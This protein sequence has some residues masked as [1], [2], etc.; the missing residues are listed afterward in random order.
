M[1]S[2][3]AVPAS[4]DHLIVGASDLDGGIDFVEERTGVRAAIGGV[5]PGRGTRNAVLSLGARCYLEILAP[6]PEQPRITWFHILPQ[7]SQP[8]LVG[9]MAHVDDLSSA[10]NRLRDVGLAFDG[11]RESSRQRPDG[12]TLRWK[13]VRLADT[14][15]GLLPMLIEWG[16]GSPHP[17]SDAPGGCGLAEFELS[18]PAPEK[19]RRIFHILGTDVPVSTADR[20]Q[21]RARIAGPD[22][23]LELISGSVVK[24][25]S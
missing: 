8:R 21:L 10:T 13:L 4:L 12:S 16:P 22:G 11:P 20:P 15:E 9:W 7:L 1:Q 25:P 6:D 3:M 17:A 24:S 19:V 2:A 23:I 14:A 5:H 18:S